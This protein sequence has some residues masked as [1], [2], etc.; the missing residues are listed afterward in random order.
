MSKG[1]ERR[2]FLAGLGA[3][4]GVFERKI[5]ATPQQD[6]NRTDMVD[7]GTE[8]VA[9][10]LGETKVSLGNLREMQFPDNPREIPSYMDN[11]PNILYQLRLSMDA[12][13][14]SYATVKHFSEINKKAVPNKPSRDLALYVDMLQPLSLITNLEFIK[15]RLYRHVIEDSIRNEVLEGIP[16]YPNLQT[17]KIRESAKS[18]IGQI[19][20]LLKRLKEVVGFLLST[21][22]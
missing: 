17:P 21:E 11:L 13:A 18:S 8:R 3:L 16:G 5:E 22:A 20:E 4:G 6:L 12:S 15:D 9:R 2:S 19:D 1:I 7:Y 10:I 14:S